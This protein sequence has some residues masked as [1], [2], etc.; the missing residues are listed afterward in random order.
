MRQLPPQSATGPAGVGLYK[1]GELAQSELAYGL[2]EITLI[3]ALV[4][5]FVTPF[6][7]VNVVCPGFTPLITAQEPFTVEVPDGGGQEVSKLNSGLA[8]V[9]SM[10]HVVP[11]A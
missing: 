1:L 5:R 10:S 7:T 3:V 11:G 2:A 6:V 4:V 9:R 8:I